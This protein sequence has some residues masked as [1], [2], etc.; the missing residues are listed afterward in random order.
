MKITYI[1]LLSVLLI[2]GCIS[3]PAS[4]YTGK[5]VAVG[6]K[7]D[8]D[9][10]GSLPDGTIFDSSVGKTPLQFTAGD[11]QLIKGFDAAVIGMHEGEEKNIT[12]APE[13]AYG[14]H[15]DSRTLDVP[16]GL[17]PNNTKVG[18]TLYT[19]QQSAVVLKLNSTTAV[20]D[21]NHPLAGKT[22]HFRVKIVKI[23]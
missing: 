21:F 8:V 22:L 16:V 1:A 3:A 20:M 18:D 10:T 12:L 17:L 14:F 7:I 5:A 11:R 19:G 4:N 2:A 9:Y 13:D 23:Y 6:D 15:N